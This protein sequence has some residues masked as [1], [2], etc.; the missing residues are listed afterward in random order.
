VT[1]I[2]VKSILIAF[3]GAIV[4]LLVWR[5]IARAGHVHPT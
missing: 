1:G 5:A 2:N 3:I 4:F